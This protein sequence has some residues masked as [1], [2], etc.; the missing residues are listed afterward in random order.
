MPDEVITELQAKLNRQY[1]H[2]HSK[3][4]LINSRGASLD[5]RDDSGYFLLCSLENL[6]SEGNFI[7]KSDMFSKRTIR[8]ARPAERV[9]TASEALALSVGER[10]GIDFGYMQQLTGK[11]KDTLVNDL[12]G[13][14]FADPLE[15]DASGEP[16]YYTADEYLSGDVR[17]KLQVAKLAAQNNPAFAVNVQALE[18]VQPK[19]LE[20]SEIA[21]RLGAT[22]LAPELIKQFADELVDAPYY[23]RDRV[24]VLYIPLTGV[25]NVTN[26][27]YTGGNIKATVTYGTQRANF[28][29]ILEESLNLRD[30][31]IFDTK[32]DMQGN[33]IRVLNAAAT[34]EAQMKQQQIEDAFKDWIWKD[35]TRRQMLVK[36]YNERFKSLRPREYDG[37][38]ILFHG[39]SPEI[40][41]RPHQKNAIAH[42]L[43]G[44]NTLLAHVVGAGKT[45]EMVA[46]AMEKKRLGLCTK[47]LICVPNHLTEQ[48]AGEALQ[49]YPNANILV[50]RRT[51]FEKANRKRFCAKIATGNY[52]IIVIGHS[53]FERIPLSQE[54][55]V[56][57]LQ[58]QIHDVINQV[59]Q[60]KEERAENFT[61]KQMER[62]R[63]QLEK[64]LDKLND[65]SRKDNV[66]T[67][68]QLGVDS[69]M[70]DEAHAFKNLAVLSKMRNVA[71]IS[72]T[73]SQRASDL[74]MK[75][76]YLD[77]IT[78]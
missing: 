76:R 70:V 6:D 43:Y 66:V 60:L 77:E 18:T 16:R 22:W 31:R 71:G 50:A 51:D 21:V 23:V 9:E 62:M 41:L 58:S 57:Y 12:Q 1:D 28:Y 34:Q 38:H 11:D 75:C 61:V 52:D 64:K 44:G 32:E 25:W 36:E 48:L 30:V 73:E 39:M 35:P 59:A 37:S 7:G 14:I 15:K 67:F 10:A 20:A 54:R 69:L 78:P 26:K 46:A 5:M 63:K 40:T 47:T 4:G 33:K 27:S 3:F 53:Q 49:L 42:I 68:E 74:Y 2:Y 72:Q 19:D 8:A 24:K 55:Q 56:E 13:V 29:H 17:H 45:Y 65:Q